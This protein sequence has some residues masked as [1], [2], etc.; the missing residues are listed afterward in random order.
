MQAQFNQGRRSV[1]FSWLAVITSLLTLGLIF[2]GAIVRVTDSGLGCGNEWPLCHGSIFP[3]LDNLTAWIE[4]SHRLFAA[5]IGIL[6]IGMLV[7]AWR[8]YRT[9]NRAVLSATVIAAVLFFV[10]SILGA[11]T[12]KLDLPPL[13]VTLHLGTAMLL[14]GALLF[15]AVGSLYLQRTSFQRDHVTALTYI[16]TGLSLVIIL[17]GALVRGSGATLIC[18]DWPLCNGQLFPVNQ[19]TLALIHMSHRYA[20]AGLGISLLLLVWYIFQTREDA[21]ERSVVIMA[22]IAYGMQAAIG[23]FYVLTQAAAWAGAMH[24]GLA[25]TTWA[26]LICLSVLETL[27]NREISSQENQGNTAWSLP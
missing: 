15:A 27:N 24:V 16:T 17:T 2:F 20:V 12:V 19:G 5:L 4:W 22:L 23:A 9:Q 26:L 25:A 13:V 14:L 11:L 18:E 6:G 10:Q 7:L 8:A 21:A 3:P 1:T